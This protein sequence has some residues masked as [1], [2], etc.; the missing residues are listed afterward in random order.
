MY[1]AKI[2]RSEYFFCPGL[3]Y[4]T[5]CTWHYI[6]DHNSL[7]S[8]SVQFL[9]MNETLRKSPRTQ[10]ISGS[11]PKIWVVGLPTLRIWSKLVNQSSAKNRLEDFTFVIIPHS[12]AQFFVRHFRVPFSRTPSFRY[13]VAFNE[14]EFRL[15]IIFPTD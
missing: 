15:R 2:W 3:F 12:S 5:S 9:Q 8:I 11:I 7:N 13:F 10:T 4:D 14:S 1:C 6:I